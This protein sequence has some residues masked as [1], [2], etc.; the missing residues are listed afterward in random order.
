MSVLY[1]FSLIKKNKFV[2]LLLANHQFG[3]HKSCILYDYYVISLFLFNK[4]FSVEINH[5]VLLSHCQLNGYL[6]SKLRN[7]TDNTH[8]NLT[9]L[10]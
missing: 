9:I 7:E 4:I 2:I 6:K 5:V 8:Q 10:N 1:L 3:I